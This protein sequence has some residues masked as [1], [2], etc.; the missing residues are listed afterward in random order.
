MVV[1]CVVKPS[2]R[3]QRTEYCTV[4]SDSVR[5][6]DLSEGADKGQ[7]KL[8]ETKKPR[9]QGGPRETPRDRALARAASIW[10][11]IGVS[12]NIRASHAASRPVSVAPRAQGR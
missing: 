6:S 11:T 8:T 9:L 5:L 7:A 3:L 10:D 4:L 2:V 12:Y 1:D